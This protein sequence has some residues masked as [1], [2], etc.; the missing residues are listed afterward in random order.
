MQALHD[1]VRFIE[2]LK[3]TEPTADKARL[4]EAYIQRFNPERAR[5]VLV[6]EDYALRFSEAR[7]GSFSN[8]VLSLS[9]LKNHDRRPFAVVVVRVRSVDFL[10]AN[11]TFLKKISHSSHQL[12]VDNIKGSFNGTDIMNEYEGLVNEPSNFELLFAQHLGFAWEE[13]LER[14]VEATNEIVGR[15]TRFRPTDAQREMLLTAP[16]WSAAALQ[17]ADF[18]A[19]ERE[20]ISMVDARRLEIL[21]AARVDNVNLRGNAIEQM[22]TGGVNAHELGDMTRDFDGGTLVIDIKTKLLDRASAPKAY[23]IDKML[24]FFSEPGS[25]FAF[26]MIGVDT[27]A[28]TVSARLLPILESSLLDATVVQHHWAGRASRG[29]TQLS[30]RF[31][32]ASEPDYEPSINVA[33]ARTF[34]EEL[35]AL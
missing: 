8:T 35:L 1:A 19:V 9:A 2:D 17:S 26:L 31:S 24:A 11:S 16:E 7:T 27:H 15:D 23:N 20:L 34:L 33:R 14:L 5:S 29:V 6:G 32:K 4:Q 25:V 18:H 12:R 13:N 28:G 30:G 22:L 21:E 3:G 10:L